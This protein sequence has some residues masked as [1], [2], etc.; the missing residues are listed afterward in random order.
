M[1]TVSGSTVGQ[2]VVHSVLY[3]SCGMM[4][5]LLHPLLAQVYTNWREQ[6]RSHLETAKVSFLQAAAL[7]CR[8]TTAYRAVN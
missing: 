1:N 4:Q 7:G 3:T 2:T 5:M 6:I 8:M